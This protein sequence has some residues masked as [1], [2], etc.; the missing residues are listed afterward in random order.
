VYGDVAYYSPILFNGWQPFAGITVNNSSVSDGG[1]SG[2]AV[3]AQTIST[4]SKTTAMPY[5]GVQYTVSKVV[6]LQAKV[7]QSPIYGTVAS[8]KAI[9]KKEI[10]KNTYLNASIGYESNG[11]DYNNAKVMVG[12][13]IDF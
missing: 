10:A 6:A 11:K 1:S 4:G 8:G 2:S 13:T 3:L 12:L 9:I 7:S 5:G